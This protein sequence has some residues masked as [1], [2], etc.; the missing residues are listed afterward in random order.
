MTTSKSAT[1]ET[2]RTVPTLSHIKVQTSGSDPTRWLYL[3]HGIYGSGRNWAGIARSLARQRPEW[4][5][6]LVD[7]RLHGDS[8]GFMAPHTVESCAKDLRELEEALGI[9]AF[10]GMTII[11]TKRTV[12]TL[13]HLKVQTP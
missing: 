8:I 13:N 11:E 3:L 9:P 6:I 10:A 7:L 4:G 12:P 1:I 5:V 2:K